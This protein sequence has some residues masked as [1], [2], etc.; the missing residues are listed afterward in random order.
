MSKEDVTQEQILRIQAKVNK[1]LRDDLDK[2]HRTANDA[3][4]WAAEKGYKP[5]QAL[6]DIEKVSKG[7]LDYLDVQGAK[8]DMLRKGILPREQCKLIE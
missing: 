3:I 7:G 8:L 5:N 4:K 6:I 2:V 1:R